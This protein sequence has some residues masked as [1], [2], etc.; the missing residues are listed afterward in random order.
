MLVQR[1]VPRPERMIDVDRLRDLFLYWQGKLA[2]RRMPA[3]RDIDP[4]EIPQ[5]LPHVM[6]VDVVD[7]GRRIR[8][9]LAGT[10]IRDITGLELT[11]RYL[12]EII[13]PGPYADYLHG[14][15]REAIHTHRPN[16]T[17]TAILSADGGY[18]R[19]TSR[20][21]APLSDDGETVNMIFAGQQFDEYLPW[22]PVASLIEPRSFEE[23]VHFI[24]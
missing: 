5:L 7:G 12:D 9:R 18:R 13:Y 6:L 24:L 10:A 19:T 20:L 21:I 16:F 11:G 23:L 15:N 3:R 17:R 14:L 2:G 1:P 4:T 8:F 22:A